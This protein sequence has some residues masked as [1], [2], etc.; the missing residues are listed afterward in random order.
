MEK[1]RTQSKRNLKDTSKTELVFT[2]SKK[3]PCDTCKEPKEIEIKTPL[4]TKEEFDI[5]MSLVDRR[6]ITPDQMKWL[7]NLNNRVLNDKKQYG[8][9]K[10]HI[11]VIKNIKNAYKRIYG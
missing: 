11:Q 7:I 1:K 10:C 9:G 4:Y 3:E 6:D 5:A 8:C 2:E